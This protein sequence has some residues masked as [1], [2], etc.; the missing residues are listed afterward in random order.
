MRDVDA[1]GHYSWAGLF[2]LDEGACPEPAVTP[3]RAADATSIP[4]G[5]GEYPMDFGGKG[6][7]AIVVL[8]AEE[9]DDALEVSFCNPSISAISW[10]RVDQD[11]S[12]FPIASCG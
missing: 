10:S 9:G 6:P 1:A 5:A 12:P 4:S 3:T 11:P 8:P 2:T 7:S